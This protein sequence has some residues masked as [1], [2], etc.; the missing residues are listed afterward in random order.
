[1]DTH[2]K[3][4]HIALT[5][6]GGVEVYTRMLIEHTYKN[7][8]TVLICASGYNKKL[9]PISS[10]TIY[11]VD[12]PREIS[13]LE[14][15]KA[16][17]K[18]RKIIKKE[19]PDVV[20]CHSSMAGA[21]GR[22]A[23]MGLGCKV[24]YNPHGWSFDMNVSSTKKLFYRYLEKIL[25]ISTDKIITISEYEKRNALKNKICKDNKIEVILNGIDLD[26]CK[27][28]KAERTA[29]GYKENDFIVGCAARLSEQKDPLLFADVA[30]CIAKKHS[31]ARFVWVG[32]GELT[33]EFITALKKN[34]VFDKTTITGWVDN[35]YE[36]ISIFDVAV[37]LSKWEGFG[38]CLAEYM[39]LG[40]PVV[41]T[42]VG[43][44]S[45][46]I[47]DGICGRLAVDRN[48]ELIADEITA[49]KQCQNLNDINQKCIK[50]SEKFDFKI[51]ADKTV[52]MIA[53]L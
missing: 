11:D 45:E 40:K 31:D 44:V 41:A 18:I 16:A 48:P 46:I 1:M 13:V 28:I 21:I 35:P 34:N 7:Y 38:L 20:Y 36:Y 52:K 19:N 37:L 32:D 24:I 39:A 2:F 27:S 49:Y 50:L 33:E 6:G 8:D 43:A 12:V 53:D 23:V 51:T 25:A 10:C 26:K 14:D 22:I 3:L 30:G 5:H 15:I 47:Q 9:L 42:N 4:L 29:L 17:L